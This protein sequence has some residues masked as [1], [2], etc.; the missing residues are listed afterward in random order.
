MFKLFG[1]RVLATHAFNDSGSST[2]LLLSK[3]SP[4]SWQPMI[5]MIQ[6]QVQHSFF[7][8]HSFYQNFAPP[9]QLMLSSTTFFLSQTF[10]LSKLYLP[11]LGSL[12]FQV[13]HSF[14]QKHSFYQKH[15]IYQ[16]FPPPPLAAHAFKDSGYQGSSA[17]LPDPR[18]VGSPCFQVQHSFYHKHSFYQNF[19]PPPFGSPCFQGQHS[20]H[21]KHSLYQKF[22]PPLLGSPCFQ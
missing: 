3:F 11:L 1:F 17:T 2:T 10:L 20:F 18:L 22:P 16:N 19:T 8:K 13:Q 4:P 12:C 5:S 9:W 7:Q 21:Q 15:S 6:V 14:D